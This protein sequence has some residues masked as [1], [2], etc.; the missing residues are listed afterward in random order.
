MTGENILNQIHTLIVGLSPETGGIE[1][2]L[3]QVLRG[4]NSDRFQFD[5]LTF[6]PRCAYEDELE[7][8][9]CKV[10]H[11]IRRGRNPIRNYLEQYRFFSQ[12]SNKYD[13]VWLHLCSAS[14]LNTILLAKRHT[15]AKVVCHSHSTSY[16]SKGGLVHR[17]HQFLHEKN[18]RRLVANTDI[19]LSCSQQAGLWLYGDIGDKLTIIPN[20]INTSEYRFSVE[21][22]EKMRQSLSMQDK[23][24][25]GHVGRLTEVKN[26]TYLIDIFAAFYRKHKDAVLV[27]VGTG[28]MEEDLRDKVSMLSLTENI[29]FMGFRQDVPE[30]MQAFDVFILPSLSEG[31]G[32]VLIE[33]QA[34]GLP[35]VVSDMVPKEVAVTN[36]VHFCSIKKSP[37]IWV[38]E[39]ESALKQSRELPEYLEN[40]IESGYS[41]QTTIERLSNVLGGNYEA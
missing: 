14:D 29:K 35:C 1:T 22:R 20:G 15:Q 27:I 37:D 9:G 34:S 24:V 36:L 6:C 33:A 17:L 38:N 7:A 41:A 2:F 16:E 30:F 12:N 39:I 21:T 40:V 8:L 18:R 5:I 4:M 26:Q 23:I 11:A 32:I 25:I 19:F 3:I 13:Y 28:E 31:L 10:F